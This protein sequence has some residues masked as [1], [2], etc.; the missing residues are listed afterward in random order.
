MLPW[1]QGAVW[2]LKLSPINNRIRMQASRQAHPSVD[3]S[4]VLGNRC[5]LCCSHPWHKYSPPWHA[6]YR[7]IHITTLC[8]TLP[9]DQNQRKRYLP[10]R[11]G[12]ICFS[13]VLSPHPEQYLAHRRLSRS[14]HGNKANIN[15]GFLTRLEIPT[16]SHQPYPG[17]LSNRQYC[18][19]YRFKQLNKLYNKELV[20]F[21]RLK[22]LSV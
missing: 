13:T 15:Q 3:G 12:P 8:L 7:P 20:P 14:I 10:E 9:C 2:P 21:N 22:G 1:R 5:A 19:S 4:T 11:A 17:W 16:T 6:V 18:S